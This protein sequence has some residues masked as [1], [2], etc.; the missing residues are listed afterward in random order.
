MSTGLGAARL[1][2]CGSRPFGR[3]AVKADGERAKACK[4]PCGCCE[5]FTATKH[6]TE[7]LREG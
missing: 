3:T 7:D 1:S 4:N 6:S 5:G 2:Q